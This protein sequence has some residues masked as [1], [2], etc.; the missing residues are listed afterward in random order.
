[1]ERT[2][3]N[4]KLIA[5]AALLATLGT[6]AYAQTATTGKPSTPPGTT[7]MASDNAASAATG[8]SGRADVKSE[9]RAKKGD[10]PR[11]EANVSAK[12]R[13]GGA[14]EAGAGSTESRSDVK[15]ETK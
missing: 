3:M 15:A 1:M 12:H 14:V 6:G 4:R 5:T 13:R 7:P 11:G 8:K 9:T 2:S 10:M